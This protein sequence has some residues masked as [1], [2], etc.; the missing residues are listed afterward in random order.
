MKLL[1]FYFS[2]KTSTCLINLL[3]VGPDK[4]IYLRITVVGNVLCRGGKKRVCTHEMRSIS[5]LFFFNLFLNQDRYGQDISKS[6]NSGR[7][8]SFLLVTLRHCLEKESHNRHRHHR[9]LEFK[10]AW[11]ASEANVSFLGRVNGWLSVSL[12]KPSP[13]VSGHCSPWARTVKP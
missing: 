13:H 3:E 4:N 2:G 9:D 6:K 10:N 12:L 8:I 5:S 7:E 11:G 1:G